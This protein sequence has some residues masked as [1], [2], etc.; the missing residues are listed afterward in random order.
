[1]FEHDPFPRYQPLLF[2]PARPAPY[3]PFEEIVAEMRAV[4]FPEID[5]EIEVR[6]GTA[7]PLAFVHVGFMHD[8]GPFEIWDMLG[9]KETVKRME[10]EGYPA[11]MWVDEMLKGGVETFYQYEG[12]NKV[13]AY[14][15]SQKKY[16]KQ[17][18]II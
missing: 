4:H 3:L 9:V 13:G 18:E 12:D 6:L 1:M 2:E 5:G 15:V 16:V 7:D 8:A 10:A 11:A 14:D 17:I